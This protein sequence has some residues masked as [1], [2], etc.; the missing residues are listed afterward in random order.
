[1]GYGFQTALG[2]KVACPQRAVVSI[3]GDGGMMF[4][5]AELATAVAHNIGL[6]SLVFNNGAYGNVRRDQLNSFDG[7]TI[8]STLTNPD[9]VKLAESFGASGYRVNS[10]ASLQPVLERALAAD[11]PALIEVMVGADAETSPWEFIMMPAN[12]DD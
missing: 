3:N 9:F 7:R 4:G 6:V 11:E 10:P 12:P 2:V 5:I 8:G 1:L